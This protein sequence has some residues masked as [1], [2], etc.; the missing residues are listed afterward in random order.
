MRSINDS[1]L[2]TAKRT[3]DLRQKKWGS[4]QEYSRNLPPTARLHRG[5]AV[6]SDGQQCNESWSLRFVRESPGLALW[7]CL[8]GVWVI[9]KRGRVLGHSLIRLLAKLQMG[10]FRGVSISAQTDFWCWSLRY[11]GSCDPPTFVKDL[12]QYVTVPL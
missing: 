6:G 1:L 2:A 11:L 5:R 10:T 3:L 4:R 8:L 7:E 9:F 12:T